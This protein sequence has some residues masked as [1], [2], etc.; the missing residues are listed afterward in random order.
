ME[1]LGILLAANGQRIGHLRQQLIPH[2]V[3]EAA[4][5]RQQVVDLDERHRQRRLMPHGPLAEHRELVRP[6]AAI[7]QPGQRILVL[8]QRIVN[9]LDVNLRI[10]T[11]RTFDTRQ[12]LPWGW[13]LHA[14][15]LGLLPLYVLHEGLQQATLRRGHVGEAQAD[16]VAVLVLRLAPHHFGLEAHLGEGGIAEVQIE[17]ETLAAGSSSLA[18]MR[19]PVELMSPHSALKRCRSR[20]TTVNSFSAR[21]PCRCSRPPPRWAPSPPADAS[22]ASASAAAGS[23]AAAASSS[24]GNAV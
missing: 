14:L 19:I 12:T 3:A 24:I 2:A 23:A 16:P 20:E 21:F 13:R 7:V 22:A 1:V 18:R 5:D 15:G 8:Q 4:V 17:I 9:R 6:I 10:H 11:A